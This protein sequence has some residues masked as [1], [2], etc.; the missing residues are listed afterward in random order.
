[1]T[2]PADVTPAHHS[3]VLLPVLAV[4]TVLVVLAGIRVGA[5]G[6]DTGAVLRA[7]AGAGDPA[8]VTIVRELRAP[9][10]VEAAL[11]GAALALAG[12]AYQAMLRN[13]LADP[14]ILGIASGAS[15]GVL[16]ALLSGI[17]LAGAWL[18]PVAGFAGAMVALLLVLRVAAVA[19]GALDRRTLI[20]A[21]VAVAAFA[22]ALV[23]LALA[24]SGDA[25]FRTSFLWLLGSLAGASWDRVLPLALVVPLAL[26]LLLAEARALN[27]LAIGETTAATLG[28]DVRWTSWRVLGAASLLTATAVAMAGPV[29]FVGLVIPHALRRRW[30]SEHRFLLP[31]S[32]C[33]GAA[34]LVVADLLA[35]TVAAPEE[36]PL[37]VI[38]AL[39]GVPVF[40]L[41]LRQR[42]AA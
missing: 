25:T 24:T 13:A 31:A 20:L 15:V 10:A 22:Q 11:V 3:R 18:L 12:A 28:V 32:A 42:R 17:A 30:G 26:G 35:R 27:A 38:T 36:L 41:L 40:V 21:G 33:V 4:G 23:L 14:Y 34:F 37:G 1:M 16:A 8:A 29:G 19:G 2:N 39:V 5:V 7:L 9:R 6:L